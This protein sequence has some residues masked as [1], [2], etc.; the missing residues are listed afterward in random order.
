MRL[1]ADVAL[2]SHPHAARLR[3]LNRYLCGCV[4][5]IGAVVLLGW[6]TGS[7]V[8]KSVLPG[9]ITM[10]V[11]T[12]VSLILLAVALRGIGRPGRGWRVTVRLCL[13]TL[14]VLAVMT[15]AEYALDID[16]RID[17]L[18]FYDYGSP[19]FPGR[20]APATNFAFLGLAAAFV[21]LDLRRAVTLGQALLFV[22]ASAPLATLGGYLYRAPGLYQNAPYPVIALN[23]SVAL[24]LLCVGGLFARSDE[25]LMGVVTSD[26]LAGSLA[27]RLLPAAVGL[28]LLIGLLVLAGERAGFYTAAFGSALLVAFCAILFAGAVCWTVTL[29]WRTESERATAERERLRTEQKL[30]E[31]EQRLRIA[32]ETARM[33]SWQLDLASG[34]LESSAQCKANFGLAPSHTLTYAALTEII[35]PD[36]R[37]MVGTAVQKALSDKEDYHA[38]YRAVWPDGS[39][40][41]IVASG[42]GVYDDGGNAVRM[43]GVTL[44]V[45]ARKTADAERERLLDAERSAR[46]DAEN[47]NRMK[48][49]F[50]SVVSHELRTPL[51]AILGWSQILRANPADAGDV[52]QGLEVIERNGRAQVA[53]IED[54]LDMGRIISG[55][56]RLDVQRVDV[57]TVIEAAV[58]SMR[59]AAEAKGVRL[60]VVLDPL[61]GPVSGDPSRLQQVVWNLLSNAIRFTPR[62]GKVQVTLERVNSHVEVTVTDTGEGIN[63]DFL[64]YVFERFRQGDGSTTRRYGGLGLGLAI[65]KN[66]V[67]L[68][69]GQV[70]A[71][72]PGEGQGATFRIALPLMPV[73]SD[74]R[75][76][77]RRHPTAD[78]D[79][80]A[81]G[82][83][84]PSLK[85]VRVLVVDDEADSRTL[86]RRLLEASEA[87]TS[88]AGSVD[89]AMALLASGN[90]DG[91]L[92][93]VLVSDIGMP[94]RD[95]FDL[96]QT[97]RKLPPD[98]GGTTPAVAL[99]A[100]ARS[101]DR[102]KA[103]LAGF[104]M[105]LAKPVDPHEL[106]AVVARLS[107]RT[108]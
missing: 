30:G 51:N 40:H 3:A 75:P 29:L 71:K 101:E 35:H 52:A 45:T 72:S 85:G 74:E 80:L 62:G 103:V 25:G 48:D 8:M 82:T 4:V 79:A 23:T 11:N 65:V 53:I 88:L 46:T 22:V 106:C 55:K 17:N 16:L 18:L 19:R 69:G 68:H 36:D 50:L 108:A 26:T 91:P 90:G 28:P 92:F 32:L 56:V 34:M 87:S 105:H 31:G 24:M 83:P 93:D 37:T 43:V 97:L 5:V 12:A 84:P 27:R 15:L 13:T 2:G 102:T 95:G 66:L 38:E 70:Y 57:P 81:R 42:R 9:M 44:D 86:V 76:A 14:S 94:E 10:K 33:G 78:D 104:D 99:T 63:P 6:A 61:A 39:V 59:P 7:P 77:G 1:P 64:P 100:Y 41:W 73:R 49:E 67:E 60:Q 96:I 107:R 20:N 89:E 21:L 47:A 98:R 54:L 58:Q